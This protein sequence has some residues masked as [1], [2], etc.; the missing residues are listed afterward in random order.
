VRVVTQVYL[1][2]HR[3]D[4]LAVG[5]LQCR[6]RGKHGICPLRTTGDIQNVPSGMIP[7]I[8]NHSYTISADLVGAEG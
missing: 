3:G 8:Y 1:G 4:Q 2:N 5:D 7:R 6:Q